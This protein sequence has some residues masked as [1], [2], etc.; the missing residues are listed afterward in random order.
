MNTRKQIC[1]QALIAFALIF[2]SMASAAQSYKLYGD[3]RT[4]S[5]FRPVEVVSPIP[6]DKAYNDLNQ[7]QQDWFRNTYYADLA[8]TE[9]PPYPAKGT[10]AIYKPIIKYRSTQ[11]DKALKGTLFV[12]AMIDEKGKVEN[13]SVYES[14]S[15]VISKLA[16][17][18][19][20]NTEFTPAN[21]NGTP[22][23]MEFPFEFKMKTLKQK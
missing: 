5:R 17:N 11:M 22:C 7:A 6:L 8:K 21:C 20:F 23:K 9:T 4:G 2:S 13:V 10:E 3:P 15:S 18:V 12:V 16:T 1:T 19:L 14:P